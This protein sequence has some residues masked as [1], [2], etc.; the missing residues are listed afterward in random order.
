MDL[1]KKSDCV[2]LVVLSGDDHG[3]AAIPV[4]RIYVNSRIQ[5]KPYQVYCI[6]DHVKMNKNDRQH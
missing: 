3:R 5:E 2:D 6:I 4:E 1:D